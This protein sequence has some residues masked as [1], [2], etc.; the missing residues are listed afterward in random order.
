MIYGSLHVHV[1]FGLSNPS[2]LQSALAS[3]GPIRQGSGT[4]YVRMNYGWHRICGHLLEQVDP[5]PTVNGSLH[6]HIKSGL[7][8]PAL[9]QLALTSHGFERQGSGTM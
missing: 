7:S 9:T 6:V 8:N 5:S 2:L 4:M 3:H 1:K